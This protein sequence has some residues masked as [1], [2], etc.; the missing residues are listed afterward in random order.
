ML[1]YLWFGMIIISIIIGTATGNIEK[2]TSA[3]LNG[4][5]GAVELCIGLLGSMCLWTGIAKVA[6]RAG[7]VVIISKLL[8]P[9][10]KILFPKLKDDSKALGAIVMNMVANML[11]MGNAATPLG[12]KAM[13]E[14]DKLNGGSQIASDEMCMFVVINTASIQ[15]IPSTLI[16][17]RQ[18]AGAVSPGEVIVPIWI[19]SIAAVVCGVLA[20]KLFQNIFGRKNRRL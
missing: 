19:S 4:A 12:L 6:E 14:L 7:L 13:A 11:G 2:V 15:L 17:M 3:M 10:T 20:A 5:G 1:N 18:A 9:I 8:R 16:A